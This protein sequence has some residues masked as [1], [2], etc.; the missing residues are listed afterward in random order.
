MK[1][2][3][4]GWTDFS[5]GDLN[6]VTGCTPV[7]EGCKNCYA[8]AIYERFGRD[9]DVTIHPQKIM[10]LRGHDWPQWSP[11]RGPGY[12]PMAF[13]CDTGDL[14]HED[15]SSTFASGAI[16]VMSDVRRVT[17]Q[18]LTK[19]PERMREMVGAHLDANRGRVSHMPSNIWFGVTAENQARVDERIPVLLNTPA[20]LRFV[21][22]EP[23]LG[24]VSLAPEW[25]DHGLDW[26]ICGAES[27]P[28]RREFDQGW[29]ESL[30]AQCA[31]AGIPFFGKQSS[32]LRPGE[33]LYIDGK[34]VL[35]WPCP[36][37]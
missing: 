20:A 32:G 29:A 31:E 15:V 22:I 17:F 9:F 2:S 12:K 4:I 16:D 37:V 10:A 24:P 13:V 3:A 1:Q 26:V 11:K 34:Q 25:L 28:K 21:S 7:S 27:G 36:S 33:P 30:Y 5:G 18:V 6:F 19:R 35:E 23:M 8:K 14:F